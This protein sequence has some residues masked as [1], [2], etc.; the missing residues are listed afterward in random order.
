MY[1]LFCKY[2]LC[3]HP[4]LIIPCTYFACSPP[5]S[6]ATELS[7][8]AP[9][10]RALRSLKAEYLATVMRVPAMVMAGR[11]SLKRQLEFTTPW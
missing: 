10:G 5:R 1:T 6:N 3:P 11:E 2:L 7:E 4:P 8:L 9:I